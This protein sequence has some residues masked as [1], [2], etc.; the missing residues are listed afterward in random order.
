MIF[1]RRAFARSRDAVGNII[2]VCDISTLELRYPPGTF[3]MEGKD[4]RLY[5]FT[6]D[7]TK[8][9]GTIDD[10]VVSWVFRSRDFSGKVKVE[11]F[12]D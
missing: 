7:W 9:C 11:I 8:R 10:E 3:M 1:D 4:G 5:T 12:N 6:H 2:L